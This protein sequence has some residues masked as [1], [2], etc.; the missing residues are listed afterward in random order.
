[1]PFKV[2]WGIFLD[3]PELF[4]ILA[5]DQYEINNHPMLIALLG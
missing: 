1:M 2:P 3:R 5:G 4:A